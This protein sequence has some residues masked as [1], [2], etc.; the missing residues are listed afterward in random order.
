MGHTPGLSTDEGQG[1]EG[2]EDGMSAAQPLSP[3]TGQL[4]INPHSEDTWLT[5]RDLSDS[6]TYLQ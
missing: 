2:R 1:A 3:G 5:S 4:P 6:W